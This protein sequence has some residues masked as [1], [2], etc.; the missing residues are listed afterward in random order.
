MELGKNKPVSSVITDKRKKKMNK[1]KVVNLKTGEPY[2]IY[3]GRPSIFGNPFLIG[4]DGTRDEV[5]KKYRHYVRSTPDLMDEIKKLRGKIL[6][7][8]CK[9][10]NCHGDILVEIAEEE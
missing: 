9:P 8:F 4:R 1:T 7:C 6:G 5:I 2:D 3:I 10:E